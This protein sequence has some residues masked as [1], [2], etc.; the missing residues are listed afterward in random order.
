MIASYPLVIAG[1]MNDAIKS[2]T[3]LG[4]VFS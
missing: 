3:D 1:T 2:L 4:P